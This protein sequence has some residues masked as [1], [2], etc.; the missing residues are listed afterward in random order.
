MKHNLKTWPE[1]FS[2]VW[3]GRKKFE[4]RVNDRNYQVGD[5]L[6]LL[7]FDPQASTYTGRWIEVT[8][9]YKLEGGQWGLP[10]NFCILSI[11]EKIL[12]GE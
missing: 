10:Q 1:P 5:D 3:A 6:L 8:I 2:E 7:E 12:R 11:Q 9:T 4:L